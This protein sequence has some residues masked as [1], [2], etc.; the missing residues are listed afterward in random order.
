[1]NYFIETYSIPT[2]WIN[3]AK[4]YY[5]GSLH[6]TDKQ[7]IYYN[8]AKLFLPSNIILSQTIA[9]TII[10]EMS[11]TKMSYLLSLLEWMNPNTTR[12]DLEI[13]DNNLNK[14]NMNITTSSTTGNLSIP[15]NDCLLSKNEIILH[16]LWIQ[17]DV[18]ILLSQTTTTDNNNNN[19]KM[20]DEEIK[21]FQNSLLLR[22]HHLLQAISKTYAFIAN[23]RQLALKINT[24]RQRPYIP[25]SLETVTVMPI[26]QNNYNCN[27]DSV[28]DDIN[29]YLIACHHMSSYLVEILD[30]FQNILID[31]NL[32]THSIFPLLFQPISTY[33]EIKTKPSTSTTSLS[34]ESESVKVSAP[35]SNKIR[36]N[37]IQNECELLMTQSANNVTNMLLEAIMI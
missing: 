15:Q 6:H 14:L 25:Y 34:S 30:K 5:Q 28:Y 7:I 31:M 24:P 23:E 19:N 17:K 13:Y 20:N 35:I 1:M 21:L 9:P 26:N 22:C 4:A 8:Q 2:E 36:M 37:T 27:K 12:N 33:N 18:Q 29:M 10:I 16:Y 11:P 32:S 3:E